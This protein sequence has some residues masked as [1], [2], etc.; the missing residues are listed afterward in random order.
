M[1]LEPGKLLSADADSADA[2]GRSKDDGWLGHPL[3]A[4]NASR[5]CVVFGPQFML[6]MFH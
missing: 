5:M 3:E 1:F 4:Q 6:E 2:G